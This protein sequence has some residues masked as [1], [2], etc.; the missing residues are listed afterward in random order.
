[1]AADA[2]AGARPQAEEPVAEEEVT[3]EL[4]TDAARGGAGAGPER[5]A[6]VCPIRE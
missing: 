1:M 6:I 3:L 5:D 4:T 2:D